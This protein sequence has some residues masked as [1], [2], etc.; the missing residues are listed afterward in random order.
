MTDDRQLFDLRLVS[1]ADEQLTRF[2]LE[3]GPVYRVLYSGI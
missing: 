2:Q 3:D 1:V